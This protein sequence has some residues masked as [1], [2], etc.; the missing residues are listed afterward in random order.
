MTREREEVIK[1]LKDI[2]E[3]ATETDY[4]VCYVTSNDEDVLKLG[5]K[6]LE[7][8]PCEDC[9]NRQEVLDQTYLWSKDEFL[10]IT[11]PFDYLRK[12]INSLSS[13]TPKQRT[14]KWIETGRDGYPFPYWEAYK[15]SECGG[16][17][18]AGKSKYCPNCGAFMTN[19]E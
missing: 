9:V 16:N 5:I 12:R 2:L 18:K 17:A 13:V 4:S 1:K 8:E 14:G 10:R 3:E 15:C 6:I 7:Q 11:N 19:G